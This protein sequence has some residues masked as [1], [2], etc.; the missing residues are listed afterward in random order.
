MTAKGRSRRGQREDQLA[1]IATQV[2]SLDTTM[3]GAKSAFLR[4]DVRAQ[5]PTAARNSI[6]GVFDAVQFLVAALTPEMRRPPSTSEAPID[7]AGAGV[8]TLATGSVPPTPNGVAAAIVGTGL[9]MPAVRAAAPAA[10][11]VPT[12]CVC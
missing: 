4:E 7:G 8:P 5:L 12:Q 11:E 9:P 2:A 6:E 10:E 1:V 3:Q